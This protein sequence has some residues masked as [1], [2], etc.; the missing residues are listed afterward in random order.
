MNVFSKTVAILS[1]VFSM[2]F[3]TYSATAHESKDHLPEA[4]KKASYAV[5]VRHAVF[6]LMGNN[7]GPL[8]GM[9]R[10]KIPFDAALAEKSATRMSQLTA[11]ITDSFKMDTSAFDSIE[12][13]A[14]DIIW[15]EFDTFSE[16]AEAATNAANTLA[17]AAATGDEGATKKAIGALGKTCG[18]CHDDYRID[19]D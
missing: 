7:A 17:A 19:K 11:M 12:T 13:E 5:D 6:T 3:F 16:K 1:A 14:K 9:L 4:E 10:G 15:E 18:S 8:F 2:L